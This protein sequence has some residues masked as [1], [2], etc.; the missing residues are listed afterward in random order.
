MSRRDVSFDLKQPF[1][2]GPCG[3]AFLSTHLP[4]LVSVV[5]LGGGGGVRCAFPEVVVVSMW[6]Q[7]L[8]LLLPQGQKVNASTLCSRVS[9][10]VTREK[11]V[12]V[13]SP[14]S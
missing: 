4:L 12:G 14:V 8:S 7:A 1:M 3:R 13:S 9:L 5:G 11:G 6:I 2:L 10:P